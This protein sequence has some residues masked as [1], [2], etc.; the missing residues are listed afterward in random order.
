[1]FMTAWQCK[2]LVCLASGIVFIL[3]TCLLVGCASAPPD[4]MQAPYPAVRY[5]LIPTANPGF[6]AHD[7]LCACRDTQAEFR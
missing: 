5:I 6:L 3:L 4:A 1:M 2:G 7:V